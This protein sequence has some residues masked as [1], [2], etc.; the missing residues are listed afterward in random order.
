MDPRHGSRVYAFITGLLPGL[1]VIEPAHGMWRIHEYDLR[2]REWQPRV[3]AV[4]VSL[5]EAIAQ[6]RAALDPH[7]QSFWVIP[8][9]EPDACAYALRHGRSGTEPR[10]R[11]EE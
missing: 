9:D 8:E 11:F 10:V 2:G 5:R 4:A 6:A 1:L 7:L 3:T